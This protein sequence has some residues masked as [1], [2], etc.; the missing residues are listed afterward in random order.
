[1]AH[2]IMSQFYTSLNLPLQEK[3]MELTRIIDQSTPSKDLQALFPQL[4]SNIFSSSFNNGW[5]LR[6]VT[7][8]T[9]KYAF[10]G[11]ISFFEP[12]G[13]MFRLC[14][15][16]LSE[17]QLKYNLP[18]TDLPI[19]L[20]MTLERGRC[21]QFYSDMLVTDSQSLNV[22]ALALNPFDYYIFNFALHL[23]SNSQQKSSW[24]NWS[25]VYF[26]LA[27][28]YLMHFL[29]ADPNVSVMPHIPNYTGKVPMAAPLQTANRPLYSPSLLLIPDLSGSSMANQHSTQNQSRNEV[30]RSETVLQV[31]IDI[32]MSVEQFSARNVE[33]FQRNYTLV[34]SSPERVRTVRVLVKHLHSFSAKHMSDPAVR[35][36]ALRKY[37][38]Q[39]MCVRAY[40]Y[41]KHLVATWPLDASFRL[42]MELWLSLIQPWRYVNNTISQDRFPIAN[43]NQ[44]EGGPTNTLDASF[45]QFIAENFPSYT[46]IF[47]LVLPRFMRL[48]LTAYKNAVML[49]RLGKVFSQQHLGPILW[50]LEQAILDCG[51]GLNLSPDTSYNN[52]GI[53]QSYTYNGVSLHKWVTIA[54]QAISE[55]NLSANFEYEPIWSDSMRMFASELVKKIISAKQTA[56]NNVQEFNRRLRLR[57]QGLWSAIKIFLMIENEHEEVALL[58]ESKKVP[59]YLSISIHHFSTIFG[60]NENTLLPPEPIIE[61]NS[62]EHSSFVNSTSFPLSITN[63]LRSKT[64]KIHYMGDPDLMPITTYEST[65]LVRMLYQIATRLNEVYGYQFNSLWNRSDLLGF[66]TRE[67]L[68]SPCVI[69]TYV[70]DVTNHQNIVTQEL[71]ARLSLRRLGSHAF[72]VWLTLGYIMFKLF[73]YSGFFYIFVLAVLWLSYVFTKASFKMLRL[74]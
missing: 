31:F 59:N 70:K 54:K 4:I 7:V 48:D 1:M 30:W 66:V 74:I 71:P 23:V 73:S 13:P 8:D 38:R 62:L 10:E 43:N 45:T 53:E 69:Q 46:C 17:P 35:S 42:V 51:S 29:P 15:K 22:V 9:N 40:H 14:Y 26:A 56:E 24:E 2:D 5:G 28:D 16:L 37:A 32:W 50:N 67:I 52:S 25:S 72:V 58:E 65:I 44:E 57:N 55:F 20:Q 19:D 34:S 49:F 12:M 18:L 63:K 27:C 36:S 68:Q 60:L 21:P 47:Q 61:D 41:I 39:I 33:S 11:L 6:T 3:L 64:T